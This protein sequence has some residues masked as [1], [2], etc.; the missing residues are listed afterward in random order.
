MS[1]L[2]SGTLYNYTLQYYS[3]TSPYPHRHVELNSKYGG[4]DRE[5]T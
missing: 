3:E 4:N 2:P 1:C 5:G